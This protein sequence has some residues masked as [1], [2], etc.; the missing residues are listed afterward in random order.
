MWIR[1]RHT[2]PG[3]RLVEASVVEDDVSR[4]GQCSGMTPEPVIPCVRGLFTGTRDDPD[5]EPYKPKEKKGGQSDVQCSEECPS[6]APA[7]GQRVE[8]DV[9]EEAEVGDP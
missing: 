2:G 7:I 6:P 9:G 8:P 5:D 3:L 4:L 1:K